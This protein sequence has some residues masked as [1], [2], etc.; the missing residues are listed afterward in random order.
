VQSGWF[1]PAK[2]Q[3]RE[4]RL[5]SG[6]INYLNRLSVGQKVMSLIIVE[7]IGF[8]LV[9]ANAVNQINIVGAEVEKMS[10]F[11]LPAF[12][13]VQSIREHI[14]AQ[15]LNFQGVLN[16]GEQVVYDEGANREY[17]KL[18][19]LYEEES[20]GISRDIRQA[21]DLISAA[22]A[23]LK[24]G[25]GMIAADFAPIN[26]ALD[27]AED[28]NLAHKMLSIEVFS[29]VEDGSFLMGRE[30]LGELNRREQTLSEQVGVL[31][32]GLDGIKQRSVAY[33]REVTARAESFTI[34]VAVLTIIVGISVI[35]LVVKRNISRPLYQLT[36]TI[37]EFDVFKEVTQGADEAA[38]MARGDELGMVTR[39]FG[40]L[41]QQ[42][43]TAREQLEAERETLEER[44]AL[45]TQE[46]AAAAVSLEEARDAANAA[47][48]A[49][50]AFLANM[51]HE[52]RTPMNAIL[53]YSEMLVE[54]AEDL[55]QQEFIPDLKKINQAGN[56]LL[57]LIND[58]LDLSKIESGKVEV[59]VEAIQL[60]ELVD[61]VAATA[62]PLMAKNANRLSIERGG[63]LGVAFQDLTKLRQTLLNLLSNAAKFTHE[64]AVTLSVERVEREDGSW[65]SFAVTDSGIGIAEHKLQTVFEEFAQADESTTRDYGGTGLGLAISRR[66]CKM[67]GGDLSVRSTVGV[68]STFT[69]NVPANLPG[70]ATAV[71]PP[72][73]ASETT[74]AINIDAAQ[75]SVVLVI[76][77]DPQACEIIERYL[78][79]DGFQV[80][81]AVSGEAG[82]RMAHELQPAAITLDVM[83]P[84]MDGWSVLR[85]LKASPDL[86]DIPVIMLTMIDDRSRGYSL[87][88]VDYLTKPVDRSQ[89]HAA[90]SQYHDASSANS[91][92]IV[93]DD[94]DTRE[95]MAITLRKNG[96]TTIEAADGQEALA[97][98]SG[99]QP[100]LIL[101]D[102]MMPVMD[103]FGFLA[104]M[105]K[106]P[107]WRNIPVIVVTA[108][109]LT[110][111]DLLRL[112][113]SVEKVLEKNAYTREELLERVRESVASLNE[114]GRSG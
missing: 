90:V 37:D 11:Y 12:E 85:A 28:A 19:L 10:G 88:A 108:K 99:P 65:L 20:T 38:L 47:N 71:E 113:G 114:G 44:V 76:D 25:G 22:V 87:G 69:V 97:S 105:R 110:A 36:R 81:T 9:T 51:S 101:L 77:D 6:L 60:D 7:L 40:Q 72:G 94:V 68:G 89:L 13:S 52:L 107:E 54:E 95:L 100:D 83:M 112:N 24:E 66:F 35:F 67:L 46:L 64:G 21:Q 30:M 32:D 16:V 18:R 42:L 82:L 58:V 74:E 55:D 23:A 48:Q 75:G 59:F 96:W 15:R 5:V 84:E 63:D 26:A 45:R 39:S 79:K 3:S 104:E 70:S 14:L 2:R 33:S 1:A 57:G 92:L 93:E 50:S 41:K 73:P 43:V 34:L 102:L 106:N 103:G 78:R 91:V 4:S 29:H 31:L 109:D 49:K 56:H 53:G 8:S 111:D 80:A 27:K 86:R 62:Q 98:M 61:E 17:Q